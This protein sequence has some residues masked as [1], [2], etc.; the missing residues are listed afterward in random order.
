MTRTARTIISAGAAGISLAVLAACS[1]A[2][3][4]SSSGSQ[5]A[6]PG[7]STSSHPSTSSPASGTETLYGTVTGSAAAAQLN[8]NGGTPT[9][10][11]FSYRG[12]VNLTVTPF[13]LPGGP[14]P[15]GTS[16]L[17]G[18]LRVHHVSALPASVSNGQAPPPTAWTYAG[19]GVCR[20]TATYD[21][22]TYTVVSGSTG[23][24]A[25]A[26][27]HGSYLITATGSAPAAMSGKP[28]TS[29]AGCAF[30]NTGK[31]GATG[32]SITFTASGPLSLPATTAL[33]TG[34][35]AR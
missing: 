27:G 30:P 24:F 2:G 15:S 34:K 1:S 10:P 28:V 22:G 18:G 14:G 31:V 35:T 25:G 11:S 23:K 12:P 26:T 29:V 9:F 6:S 33:T 7:A 16:I 5:P 19:N 3:S 13:A 4:S 17:P 32:A 20:F 21:K 8:S